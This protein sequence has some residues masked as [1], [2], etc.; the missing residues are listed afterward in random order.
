MQVEPP[1]RSS[2]ASKMPFGGRVPSRALADCP[3]W[4]TRTIEQGA[5]WGT[6]GFAERVLTVGLQSLTTKS[7][8]WPTS[9]TGTRAFSGRCEFNLRREYA[10]KISERKSQR[11]SEAFVT[12]SRRDTPEAVESS[13]NANDFC[14]V[15]G[16]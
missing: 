8:R 3:W 10:A 16:T 2:L 1:P 7:L 4:G 6:A 14:G 5:R 9:R 12:A 11:I 15:D 13:K